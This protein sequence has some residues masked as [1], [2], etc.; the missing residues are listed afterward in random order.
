[1][2]NSADMLTLPA[3]LAPL[4]NASAVNELSAL[5]AKAALGKKEEKQ[6]TEKKR[7]KVK[8]SRKQIL[9]AVSSRF[10]EE[11]ERLKNV[12]AATKDKLKKS[13]DTTVQPLP[14]KKRLAET[15]KL[16]DKLEDVFD[17]LS[18]EPFRSAYDYYALNLPG[19]SYAGPD[20]ASDG[21]PVE[22][23]DR[24]N[25]PPTEQNV[26][27]KS[28]RQPGQ[29]FPGEEREWEEAVHEL[30]QGMIDRTYELW[31]ALKTALEET[32][33][34]TYWARSWI[35][36][37]LKIDSE[38][39]LALIAALKIA[40]EK[41]CDGNSSQDVCRVRARKKEFEDQARARGM[42]VDL[43]ELWLTHCGASPTKKSF[44]GSLLCDLG[45]DSSMARLLARLRTTELDKS[46]VRDPRTDAVIL[47]FNGVLQYLL[48]ESAYYQE[49]IDDMGKIVGEKTDAEK[50]ELQSLVEKRDAALAQSA[51]QNV[52]A[53][54]KLSSSLKGFATSDL[55]KQVR[56]A[57]QLRFSGARYSIKDLDWLADKLSPI[58]GLD[59]TR[60]AINAQMRPYGFEI[61]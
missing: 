42:Q 55:I 3:T 22:Y 13:S 7:R 5:A 31:Q 18:E 4:G 16:L 61:P 24:L 58:V 40:L 41:L 54:S 50:E 37:P 57:K 9:E 23:F 44:E 17:I 25:V 51:D 32:E 20:G 10:G 21:L 39:A 38:Q 52:S 53:F 27:E 45:R 46:K 15:S 2:S 30:Y 48:P 1:M 26:A 43:N 60:N 59:T 12:L 11:K 36:T 35:T 6:R 33:T 28:S 29:F 19:L 34:W 47:I 56:D 49:L 8:K 14:S